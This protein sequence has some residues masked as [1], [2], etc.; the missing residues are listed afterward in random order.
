MVAQRGGEVDRSSP[1]QQADDQVAQGDM[2][3]GPVP[4]RIWEASSAKV[5]SRT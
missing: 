1:A 5:T 2:T 4:D 3:C